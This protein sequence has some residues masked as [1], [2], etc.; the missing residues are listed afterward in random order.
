MN[1]LFE[2]QDEISEKILDSLSL[3]LTTGTTGFDNRKYF[4]TV[5][6][7]RQSMVAR[8]EFIKGTPEGIIKMN[9]TVDRLLEDEPNNPT[10]LYMKGWAIIGQVGSGLMEDNE[11]NAKRAYELAL[12]SIKLG[13]DLAGAYMLA[14]FL[15][16]QNKFNIVSEDQNEA[17]DLAVERARKAA[18][19]DKS[20]PNNFGAIG[21]TLAGVGKVEEAITFYKKALII[22][23]HAE[24]WIKIGYIN[25]LSSIKRF[26][27]A[28]IIA[29]EI[30]END[31]FVAYVRGQALAMLA[32][33]A[34]KEDNSK[35]AKT[36]IN[37]FKL[38]DF[39]MNLEGLINGLWNLKSNQLFINDYKKVMQDLGVT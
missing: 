12:Q 1:D 14:S 37:Q 13:P 23:P 15:E 8:A 34:F 18:K 24:T 16:L 30:S 33:I 22:A 19:L 7:W 26:D 32:Y 10:L 5:D 29:N 28:K 21:N 35:L 39:Q 31:Q 20:S 27:E 4:Q 2:I 17:N 3:K 6:N 11:E 36:Y 25:A 9:T 38:L